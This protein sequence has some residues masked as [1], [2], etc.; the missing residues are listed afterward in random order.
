MQ[1]TC[2]SLPDPPDNPRNRHHRHHFESAV[3]LKEPPCWSHE[4]TDTWENIDCIPSAVIFL[5]T[6]AHICLFTQ[7]S[8]DLL[9]FISFHSIFWALITG[10]FAEALHFVQ[11]ASWSCKYHSV[12]FVFFFFAQ[13]SVYFRSGK[14]WIEFQ[15]GHSWLRVLLSVHG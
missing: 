12:A 6:A 7:L 3:F 8:W 2:M 11:D 9:L 5:R 1:V 13:P 15:M 4:R 10:Y 14:Q